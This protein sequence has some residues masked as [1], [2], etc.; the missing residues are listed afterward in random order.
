M[1]TCNKYKGL[2]SNTL[3]SVDAHSKNKLSCFIIGEGTLPIQCAKLLL[4]RGYTLYGIISFDTSI[5]D[6]AKNKGIPHIQPT[7]NLIKF[8]SQQPFDY[9]FSIVNNFVLPQEILELPRQCP[10]NYHDAP[11]PRYAGV[12]AT[13]WALMHQEKTHGITWHTM[14]VLVD[15]GDI[16]KQEIIDIADNETA[17]TLNGKCYEAAI[18][19]FPR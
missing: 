14:A 17:L 8:L 16:L 6:W 5:S 10:I 19:A 2:I 3:F 13:S 11:L 18:Y 7:D 15:A 12:N 1:L 4:N 9:L